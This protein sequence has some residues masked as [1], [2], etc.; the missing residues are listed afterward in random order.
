MALFVSATRSSN[1]N[2]IL[3]VG[4]LEGCYLDP[5]YFKV[6]QLISLVDGQSRYVEVDPKQAEDYFR[7]PC[8]ARRPPCKASR[9]CSHGRY[10]IKSAGGRPPF[11]RQARAAGCVPLDLMAVV[12]GKPCYE[13]ALKIKQ[14]YGTAGMSPVAGALSR[15]AD[16]T[17]R[18]FP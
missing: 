3:V 8:T 6:Q 2:A 18:V 15:A 11:M 13:R 7:V 1:W 10:G 9:R 16:C 17:L 12:R 14:A 5:V 4:C